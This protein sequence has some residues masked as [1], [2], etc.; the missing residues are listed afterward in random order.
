MTVR[1]VSFTVVPTCFLTQA[2]MHRAS[3]GQ[4]IHP[5]EGKPVVS[6]GEKY[7]PEC[8]SDGRFKAKQCNNAE[9]CWCVNNAG[10]RRTDSGDKDLK[11]DELVETV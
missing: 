1:R 6:A 9:Q 11:C 7:R 8:E 2:E 4:Q 3:E 10:V 5:D